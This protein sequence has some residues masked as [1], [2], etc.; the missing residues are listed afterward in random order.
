MDRGAEEAVTNMKAFSQN[1]PTESKP[2]TLLMIWIFATTV[3]LAGALNSG[4]FT[5]ER[6]VGSVAL[7]LLFSLACF[8]IGR[9]VLKSFAAEGPLVHI[10]RFEILD[11]EVIV[12][13]AGKAER[14]KFPYG[15]LKAIRFTEVYIKGWYRFFYLVTTDGTETEISL[16]HLTISDEEL[17]RELRRRAP[18]IP[19]ETNID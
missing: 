8:A 19:F 11:N 2:S 15:D 9:A 12:R 17:V 5:R 3:F 16:D 1:L 13:D 7:S 6:V 10:P 4:P 14:R 18:Q